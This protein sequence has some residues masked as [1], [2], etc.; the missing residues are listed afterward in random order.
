M[1]VFVALKSVHVIILQLSALDDKSSGKGSQD[2]L[3]ASMTS[4]AGRQGGSVLPTPKAGGPPRVASE[5]DLA[6]KQQARRLSGLRAPAAGK[7]E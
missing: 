1:Y 3:N 6:R 7:S 5:E 2:S 4:S